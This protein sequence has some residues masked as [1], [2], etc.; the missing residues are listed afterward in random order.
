MLFKTGK[1]YKCPSHFLM[2]Y[3][4]KE[5]AILASSDPVEDASASP[6]R[7]GSEVW[8]DYLSKKLGSCACGAGCAKRTQCLHWADCQVRY[9]ELGEIFMF[10]ERDRNLFHVLF[11]DKQ[12]W[13]INRDWIKIVKGKN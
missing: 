8:V 5:K 12:G 13:I 2:I 4:T 1:L 11:G 7:Y 6:N 3:P 10:L 9:S